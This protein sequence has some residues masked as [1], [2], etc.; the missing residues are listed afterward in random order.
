M[1]AFRSVYVHFLRSART[2]FHIWTSRITS[3][4]LAIF[5]YLPYIYENATVKHLEFLGS[6][7]LVNV[8]NAIL[9]IAVQLQHSSSCNIMGTCCTSRQPGP[10]LRSNSQCA[11]VASDCLPSVPRVEHMCSTTAR[12]ECDE[13]VAL[14]AP[15]SKLGLA[16]ALSGNQGRLSPCHQTVPGYWRI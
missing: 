8:R 14:G 12:A 13:L 15:N 10:E 11:V 5:R 3:R 4:P 16:W 9:K 2:I 1:L 6:L 7:Q